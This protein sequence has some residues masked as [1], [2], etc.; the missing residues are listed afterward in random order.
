MESAEAERVGGCKRFGE[1][2]TWHEIEQWQAM[3]AWSL[4]LQQAKTEEFDFRH[5]EL[6]KS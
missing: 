1:T 4:L 6:L 3:S 2:R 5:S